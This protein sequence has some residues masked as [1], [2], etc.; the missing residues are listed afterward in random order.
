M[1]TWDR[2]RFRIDSCSRT[3][4]CSIYSYR[5]V[6]FIPFELDKQK[7]EIEREKILKSE[8]KCWLRNEDLVLDQFSTIKVN[9]KWNW[10]KNEMQ[11]SIH[12]TSSP[13]IT[14]ASLWLPV[15]D[16][17]VRY[18]VI[19]ASNDK[20]NNTKLKGSKDTH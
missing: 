15:I 20:N 19:A 2:F 13:T 10:K 1:L 11:V 4:P 9:Q 18:V 6:S 3:S 12:W 8:M 17:N 5:S 14:T 7:K 16:R